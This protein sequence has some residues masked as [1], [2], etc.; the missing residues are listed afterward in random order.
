M[1]SPRPPA[2][3]DD[4]TS[5]VEALTSPLQAVSERVI[6]QSQELRS[7]HHNLQSLLVED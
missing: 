7:L 5:Q 3:G 6:T 2:L 4:V 1:P